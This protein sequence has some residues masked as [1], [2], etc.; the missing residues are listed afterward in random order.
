V[1]FWQVDDIDVVPPS[2]GIRQAEQQLLQ[3]LQRLR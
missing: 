3:L 1:E 2:V